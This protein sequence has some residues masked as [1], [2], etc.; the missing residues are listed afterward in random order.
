MLKFIPKH[1][2][3]FN[4]IYNCCEEILEDV[5]IDFTDGD[6]DYDEPY[7]IIPLKALE[8]ACN[9]YC[10]GWSTLE[11]IDF[12]NFTG[13]HMLWMCIEYARYAWEEHFN[14]DNNDKAIEIQ[15]ELENL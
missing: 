4:Y 1:F 10:D 7:P 11:E 8:E 9:K 15:E 3:F 13:K 2:I 12:K 5:C 6:W 14:F